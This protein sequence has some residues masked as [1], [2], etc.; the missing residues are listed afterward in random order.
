MT[1]FAIGTTS[2]IIVNPPNPPPSEGESDDD[3]GNGNGNGVNKFISKRRFATK[4][5]SRLAFA[6]G[7]ICLMLLGMIFI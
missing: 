4:E 2:S 6:L 5:S 1:T 7:M 3:D